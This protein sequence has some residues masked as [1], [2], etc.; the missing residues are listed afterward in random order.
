MQVY[1]EN[2]ALRPHPACGYRL[3]AAFLGRIS[4]QVFQHVQPTECN[5]SPM[6]PSR[7]IQRQS[8]VFFVVR[9]RLSG[10]GFLLGQGLMGNHQAK[11]DVCFDLPGVGCR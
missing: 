3:Q 7:S 2:R 8:N 9:L 11:L 1:K 10:G 4:D 5:S 6:S